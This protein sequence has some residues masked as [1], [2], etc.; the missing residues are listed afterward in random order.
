[1]FDVY[2]REVLS[3]ALG[4][5]SADGACWCEIL[6]IEIDPDFDD[7]A[8]GIV[9]KRVESI[10]RD[11]PVFER[12]VV[13][14]VYPLVGPEPALFA[15]NTQKAYAFIFVKRDVD[16]L[17]R[18]RVSFGSLITPELSLFRHRIHR[19]CQVHPG[20]QN[21][22]QRRGTWPLRDRRLGD[23]AVDGG[24]AT[25][26]WAGSGVQVDAAIGLRAGVARID[27]LVTP[28][29]S[30]EEIGDD[31]RTKELLHLSLLAGVSRRFDVF[32][33]RGLPPSH[34]NS[35]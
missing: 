23:A 25:I 10:V 7:L 26:I 19:W 30:G 12:K 16:E 20:T 18:T 14:R 11:H 5:Y 17:G 24:T 31:R 6:V 22:G 28:A 35:Q 13:D 21:D 3:L 4:N 32:A 29:A 1:M 34:K 33:K 27:F 9:L 15:S 8:R 2:L